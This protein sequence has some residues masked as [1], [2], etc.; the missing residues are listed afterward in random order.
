ML[1]QD[2]MIDSFQGINLLRE[3]ACSSVGSDAVSMKTGSNCGSIVLSLSSEK[4]LL[5]FESKI[6][7]PPKI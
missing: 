1:T 3:T 2:V 4:S 5:P 7:P 6:I